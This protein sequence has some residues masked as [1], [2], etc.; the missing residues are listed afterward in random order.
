MRHNK[1]VRDRIPE[2]IEESGQ[3]AVTR[4]LGDGEYE[5]AL[6]LKLR[7]ETGEYEGS[8]E[9]E[10][11]ADILEA[12]YALAATHGIGSQELERLRERKRRARGGFERRLL[13]IETLGADGGRVDG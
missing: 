11:L 5:Q 2:L 1:L 4:A 10:E 3:Q 9:V 6:L 12:V 13:L 7:E 8:R